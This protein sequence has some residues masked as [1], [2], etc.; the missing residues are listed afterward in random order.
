MRIIVKEVDEVLLDTADDDTYTFDLDQMRFYDWYEES[1]RCVLDDLD[2]E[3][4]ATA[5]FIYLLSMKF[6]SLNNES[7]V[8]TSQDLAK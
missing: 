7:L 8:L 1:V 6:L 5:R 3:G 2:L 4:P